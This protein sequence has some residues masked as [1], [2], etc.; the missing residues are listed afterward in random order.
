[1]RFNEWCDKNKLGYKILLADNVKNVN[2]LKRIINSTGVQ[3][4][5]LEGCRM[6]DLARRIVI[7]H[8][9]QDRK[10]QNIEV[11]DPDFSV[12]LI[13]K[14][15]N[16][17]NT[18]KYDFIPKECI[19]ME[20]AAELL[21]IVNILRAGK[22]KPEYN[23]KGRKE[24]EQLKAIIS[25]YEKSLR[26]KGLH[27]GITLLMEATDI[28]KSGKIGINEEIGIFSYMFPYLT[29][30]E[31]EFL[32]ALTA[33]PVEIDAAEINKETI[34]VKCCNV[35]GQFN[36]IQKVIND[37]SSNGYP[38]G[39]INIMYSSP[40]YEN[41]IRMALNEQGIPATF[42]SGHSIQDA[43][44]I[45][46]LLALL[47]WIESDYDY[48]RFRPVIDNEIVRLG[49]DYSFGVKAGIGWSLDRYKLFADQMNN[50]RENYL[51]VMI[52]HGRLRESEKT[53]P[54]EGRSVKACSDE[55][56]LFVTDI[57]KM[58]QKY[59]QGR[60]D[61][62]LLY[63]DLISFIK[64][65]TKGCESDKR[66]LTIL[67]GLKG[68][69]DLVGDASS[70]QEAISFITEKISS[71]KLSDDE[72]SNEV[73]V[74]QMG[75]IEVLERPYQYGIGMSYEAFGSKAVDSPVLSD[76][77]LECLVD[78][79]VIANLTSLGIHRMHQSVIV[80]LTPVTE[81]M[82]ERVAHLVTC[83]PVNE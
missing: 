24:E 20:T 57:T 70:L 79:D 48:A 77:R 8:Y 30:V 51:D 34:T 37:I 63:R 74:M 56:V 72:K 10:L 47:D 5:N 82:I 42:S 14:L 36:E 59:G 76:E 3:V 64:Y 31:K 25:D 58:M 18:N 9:A 40:E 11:V 62:S 35:Y 73:N 78:S 55:F 27:D 33:N 38:F 17:E 41:I 50:N 75:K 61:T 23:K 68:Y 12:L 60:T 13:Y 2:R 43:P 49:M 66:T 19:C 7:E 46:L 71:I 22:K 44:Y 32:G 29:Y 53:E 15:L 28:I 4:I 6:A 52:K 54:E 67:E 1:M 81:G 26:E 21:R 39:K 69:F 16:N 83:E 65:K 80:E 45:S